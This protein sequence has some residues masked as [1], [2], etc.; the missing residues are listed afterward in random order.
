MSKSHEHENYKRKSGEDHPMFG[1]K[2]E[3]HPKFGIGKIV[4]QI[5]H[6]GNV[7]E[8]NVVRHFVESGF[9]ASGI[10][11]VCKGKQ[12]QHKG[13]R[14]KYKEDDDKTEQRN[15][16]FDNLL[17]SFINTLDN[18]ELTYEERVNRVRASIAVVLIG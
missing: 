12:I 15:I 1:K 6:E 11:L 7:V 16:D 9:L 17:T 14:W 18:N 3:E 10:S 4:Q 5:D 13:F 2:G 8:E